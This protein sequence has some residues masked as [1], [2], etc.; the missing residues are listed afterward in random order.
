MTV[1]KSV[2][3][4]VIAGEEY[5]L[6][7]DRPPEYTRAV[8]EHVDRTLQEILGPG[9]IVDPG[10]CHRPSAGPGL[11]ARLHRSGTARRF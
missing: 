9:T 4:V 2:V 10:S 1:D 8:A 6:K 5:T 11:P 3:K 7:S